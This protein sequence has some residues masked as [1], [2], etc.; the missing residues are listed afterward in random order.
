MYNREKENWISL[1]LHI[2]FCRLERRMGREKR[3]V[4]TVESDELRAPRKFCDGGGV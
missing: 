3:G 2:L 4:D 1:Y